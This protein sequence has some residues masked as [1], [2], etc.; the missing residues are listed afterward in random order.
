M[1][2]ISEKFTLRTEMPL[3]GATAGIWMTLDTAEAVA[4]RAAG[5]GPSVPD[6]NGTPAAGTILR[7]Q[8][9]SYNSSGNIE[10]GTSP[11]LSSV[12]GK[13]FFVVFAGN[14]DFSGR[15]SNGKVVVIHGGCRFDTEKYASGSFTKGAPLQL[16]AGVWTQKVYGDH[17]QIVGYVGPRGLANG[18]LDVV[19]PQTAAT[20]N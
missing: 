11:D 8:G 14:N 5:T 15:F 13:L 17:K 7:G 16:V 4:A 19:M 6:S 9:V 20:G 3:T 18:V 12:V 2:L 10:L 1:A